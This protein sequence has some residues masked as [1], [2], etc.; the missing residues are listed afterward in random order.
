MIPM[1][2]TGLF[3]EPPR[4]D[5]EDANGCY[6]DNHIIYKGASYV[7]APTIDKN[8]CKGCAFSE[9]FG[10]PWCKTED[11]RGGLLRC[12]PKHRADGRDI[13]WVREVM[14]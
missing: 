4:Y 1:H 2:E 3:N 5:T 8:S 12:Q 14:K 9:K 10:G 11:A 7:P 6:G 13:R